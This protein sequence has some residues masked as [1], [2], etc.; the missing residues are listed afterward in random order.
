VTKS[1]PCHG[2]LRFSSA[3][4]RTLSGYACT[5]SATF[6]FTPCFKAFSLVI[7]LAMLSKL[8]P[9]TMSKLPLQPQASAFQKAMAPPFVLRRSSFEIGL[10]RAGADLNR[11]PESSRRTATRHDAIRCW[12][13][14]LD[15]IPRVATRYRK[16]V[17]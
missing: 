8:R 4:V 17:D 10:L 5:K 3:L 16:L 15:L 1:W 11:Q 13:T 12:C 2:Q 6:L 14:P 9:I 7:F